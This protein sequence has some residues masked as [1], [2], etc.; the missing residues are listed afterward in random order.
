MDGPRDYHTVQ[1]KSEGE[2][3]ISHDITHVSNLK[4]D[5]NAPVF[6]AEIDS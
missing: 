3:Q 6:K 2:T 1:S 5:R 4:Y